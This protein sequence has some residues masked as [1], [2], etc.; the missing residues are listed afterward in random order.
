MV[1]DSHDKQLRSLQ[2]MA[3]RLLPAREAERRTVVRGLHDGA[4]QALSAIRMAASA[5]MREQDEDLRQADLD[6]IIAQ[7]GAALAQLRE[8]SNMLR[9]PQL[10][11]LGLEAALRWHAGRLD[12]GDSPAIVLDLVELPHRPPP[13][14]EQACFRIAEQA[15]ANALEHA[16]AATITVR[17]GEAGDGVLMEIRDDGRGFDTES[18]A[19]PGLAL[20]REYARG[21]AG[22]YALI[23]APGR[24]TCVQV[25]LPR[26]ERTAP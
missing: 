12:P 16:S 9:P 13:E 23:S 5:A 11:A 7:A 25:Q 18:V 2:A 19:G 24:G 26:P 21:I 8:I 15:L 20:M 22:R 3:G 6:D 4:G 10:D 17:L 1:S 14:A